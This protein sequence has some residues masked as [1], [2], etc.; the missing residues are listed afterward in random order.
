MKNLKLTSLLFVFGFLCSLLPNKLVAQQN[1]KEIIRK[2]IEIPN[3]ENRKT[4]MLITLINKN[5]RTRERKTVSYSKDIGKDKKT[6]IFT[7]EPADVKGTAF[8]SWEYDASNKED[9]NWLYL[10]SMKKT[11]RISGSTSKSGS[12]MGTDFT[13]D[14]MGGRNIDEDNYK[15][16]REEKLDGYDCWVIESVPVNTKEV[17]SKKISWIRK[18]NFIAIKIDFYDRMKTNYKALTVSNIEKINGFW[19]AKKMEMRDLQRNHKTII[20]I[21]EIEYNVD[22]DDNYF[23]VPTLE[24]GIK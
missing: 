11:R 22:I 24:N 2:S 13:Y 5:N 17:F 16:L 20:E 14:D 19:T 12:F 4:I 18:D 23:T 3:G 1:A 7:L 15:L 21:A 10:P 6:L 9:D 8:L